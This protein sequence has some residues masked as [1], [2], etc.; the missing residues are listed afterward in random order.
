MDFTKVHKVAFIA[1]LFCGHQTI[2]LELGADFKDSTSPEIFTSSML[3][4]Q[5]GEIAVW[6]KDVFPSVDQYV[7]G[8][9]SWMLNA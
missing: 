2:N 3:I 9:K 7:I 5:E 1:E 6:L 4:V 8:R